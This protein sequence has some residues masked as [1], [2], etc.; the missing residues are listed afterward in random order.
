HLTPQQLSQVRLCP[1]GETRSDSVQ[2][3]LEMMAT[4]VKTLPEYGVAIHDGV[5]PFVLPEMIRQAFETAEDKGASVACVPVKFSLR[6]RLSEEQSQPVDRV[7]FFEVQT[8]QTFR[9]DQILECYRLRPTG[10]FT[11]DAS[12]YQLNGGQ[13]S[14][15]EGSYDNIKLT[16]PEDLAIGEAILKRQ[17]FSVPPPRGSQT[18]L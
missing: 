8:P 11:D 14:I 4:Q 3:G 5:R 7:H 16:T 18:A 1:G 6:Q 2:A 13:V 10:T 15:C 12:L 9:L 17:D